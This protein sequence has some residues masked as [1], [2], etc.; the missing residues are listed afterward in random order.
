[1]IYV[2]IVYYAYWPLI[3]SNCGFNK[4]PPIAS[5]PNSFKWTVETCR[6]TNESGQ[7]ILQVGRPHYLRQGNRL[8]LSRQGVFGVNRPIA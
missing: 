5:V 2:C 8:R 6:G 1:M 4:T 7:I 3:R